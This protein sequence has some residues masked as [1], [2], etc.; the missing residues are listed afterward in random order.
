MIILA[1]KENKK[2]HKEIKIET[3]S[4]RLLLLSYYWLSLL[5]YNVNFQLESEEELKNDDSSNKFT[6]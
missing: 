3:N 2:R 5:N 6:V 1:I 4:K